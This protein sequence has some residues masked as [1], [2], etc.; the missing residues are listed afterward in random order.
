MPLN[1][2]LCDFMY[3]PI[4]VLH[5]VQNGDKI[6]KIFV[7]GNYCV[8]V[9][10]L[11]HLILIGKDVQSYPIISNIEYVFPTKE[12][13]IVFSDNSL[14]SN[15]GEKGG[16]VIDGEWVNYEDLKREEERSI[17]KQRRLQF[18][19]TARRMDY[20]I[21]ENYS[22]SQVEMALNKVNLRY[23][24]NVKS[25]NSSREEKKQEKKEDGKH[26]LSGEG[27][28][29]KSLKRSS[30]TVFS[31]SADEKKIFLLKLN[32][33]QNEKIRL[34]NWETSLLSRWIKKGKES[35]STRQA[36]SKGIPYELRET[37]W[38]S[39]IGIATLSL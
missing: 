23:S 36:W 30:D 39:A 25:L 35:A 11:N 31:S 3:F 13:G 2:D 15:E 1:S 19:E 22:L 21:I 17:R 34:E 6:I 7:S 27:V 12:G 14:S 9:S 28:H 32:Q 20:Y 8:A 26:V 5:R 4:C 24:S 29:S 38:K 10:K 16:C 37:M 18:K 33:V